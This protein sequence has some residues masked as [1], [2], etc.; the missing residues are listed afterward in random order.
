V[1]ELLVKAVNATHSDPTK[2]AVG[3]YKRGDVVGVAP[4]GWTWGALEL[5][6]PA[7]GGKFVVLKIT[8]VTRQQ[9]INWVR[10]NWGTEIDGIDF[11]NGSAVRRRR[12]RI[13]V[14]SVPN[15][16]RNTMNNTGQYSTTWAAIRQYLRNKQTNATATNSPIE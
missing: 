6:P 9:V 14:D 7:N 2:D 1:A 11:V 4:N 13:D 16:V 10:N 12:V 8:D 15:N 5:N 3:C